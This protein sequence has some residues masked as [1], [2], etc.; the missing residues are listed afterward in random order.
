MIATDTPGGHWTHE[1]W[2][3]M[4][5]C[6][7]IF[8]DRMELNPGPERNNHNVITTMPRGHLPITNRFIGMV[9]SYAV[10]TPNAL[11]ASGPQFTYNIGGVTQAFPDF[12]WPSGM[13]GNKGDAAYDNDS[14][15]VRSELLARQAG[16]IP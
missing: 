10:L 12:D 16:I 13:P 8:F 5:L 15:L 9:L 14:N 3:G 11:A 6:G 2:E 4:D 1:R 7:A